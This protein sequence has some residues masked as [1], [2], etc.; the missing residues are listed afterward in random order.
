MNAKKRLMVL[1]LGLGLAAGSQAQTFTLPVVADTFLREG[2]ANQ[3]GGG[4]AVLQLSGNQRVLLRVDQAAVISAAGSGRLVS[5]S[6]E[7]Y[8]RSAS[9]WGSG[10]Q[11]VEAHRLTADW[12]EAGATWSCGIDTQPTNGRPDCAAQWAG[13]TFEED[14]SDTVLHTNDTHGWVR[15]DVTA[16][17]AAFLAGASNRGWLLKR[18]DESGGGRADYASREGAAAERPRLVLLVETS[19]NDQVPPSLAITAPVRSILVNEPSPTV[20]LEY[21]DGG[22]GVDTATLQLLLDGQDATASCTSGPQSA[23]CHP[24]ALTAGNHTL[25]ARLRDRSGNQAQASFSFQ[26]LLGTG[27]HLVA[28]QAVADTYV[29]KGGANQNQGTEPVV[30]VQQGGND[31]VLVQFDP[32]SLSATLAG[33][34]LVSAALELHV[35][36]NGRNWGPQGRTVD[37]HRVTSAWT[38][39]G[40]SWN[41]P[42]DSNP[43]NSQPDCASQWN[44]G[45]FAAAP[46]A[47]VLHTRDLAGWVSFNVTADVAAFVSGT[48]NRGWLIKKTDEK[49]SGRMDYD[50]RQGTAREGPRLVVVFEAA[51]GGDTEAPV[52]AVTSPAAGSFVASATPTITATYSDGGSGVD[53]ASVRLLLD[54]V[55]RTAAA[56]V[57]A[58]GLTFTPASSLAEGEHLVE[59]T[60][61]DSA[62]NE[63]AASAGFTTDTG[64]PLLTIT[65]PPSTGP[66]DPTPEIAVAYSDSTSGLDLAALRI[67]LDGADLLARCVVSPSSSTCEPQSLA[68]GVHEVAASIRDRAGNVATATRTFELLSDDVPPSITLTSPAE[69]AFFK[70]PTILVSGH[71]TDNQGL[72]SVELNGTPVAVLAG[73]AFQAPLALAEGPNSL[74]VTAEDTAGNE[75]SATR[76]VVLD[77]KPPRLVLESPSDGQ[78]T[79][80]GAVRVAGEVT[81]DQSLAELVIQGQ[82]VPVAGGRFEAS[83]PLASGPNSILVRAVDRAGNETAATVEV[84][85]FTL[86]N[87]TITSP[88]DL[89]FLAATTVDVEGTVSDAQSSVAVNGVA[90]EISGTSYRAREVPLIEGGNILTATA[91]DAN[92]H[93]GSATINVVRDLTA[94]R[95]AITYPPSE[96]V[97]TQPTVAVSGMVNDIVAGT[98]NAA[99]ATV[100]VNGLPASVSNRSF[101]VRDVPLTEGENV[102]SVVATDVSGNVGEAS[103]T[104]FF[105]APS[106]ARISVVSGDLQEGVIGTALPAPLVVALADA[107]G[108][109]VAGRPVLFKVREGSGTLDGG[110]RLIAVTTDASGRATAHFTLGTRSGGASDVV[111]A[112]A[113]GYRG[114]AVFTAS[115]RSGDPAHLVVDS[116]D[117]Q[118]GTAGQ[119]LPRP[120]V[121]VVTDAGFNRLEGFPIKFTIKKGQGHFANGLQE[122]LISSDS[123]GRAIAYLVLDTEEGVANNVVEAR[124]EGLDPSPVVG[125]VA[126]GWI[127]GDPAMTSVSGVVLDNSNVPVAGATLR[128]L[129]TDL[130]AQ[131][132]EQGKFLIGGAPV[133]TVKLIVDGST[134]TRPGSW[135]DL[136]FVLTTIAGRENTI[137]MPIYLLPLD[138]QNGAVIDEVR[139][140]VITLPEIPGFAL[141]IAPGSVIFPGG[142]RSG[143]VS[144]TAVHN[145][146]VPMVPNFGQQPRFIVTIQPA[147]ARFDPPARLILPNVEGLAPGAV[148]EMY[149]FDHDLGH[150][151]SIGP[152]TVSEDGSV[153]RSNPGV[154]ILKAGWHCGGN[155]ATAGTPHDCPG[156]T[157]CVDNQCVPGC[158]LPASFQVSTALP[159]AAG[160][161]TPTDPCEVPPGNCLPGGGCQGVPVNVTGLNGPCIVEQGTLASFSASSNEDSK[162][163]WTASGGMPTTGQGPSFDVQFANP[164]KYTVTAYCK[165]SNDKQIDV[166]VSC[167]ATYM[168]DVFDATP[169]QQSAFGWTGYTGARPDLKACAR[170]TQACVGL[171]AYH[172]GEKSEVPTSIS[173]KTDLT[174]VNAAVSNNVINASNCQRVIDDFTPFDPCQGPHRTQFWNSVITAKHEKV[175]YDQIRTDVI[176]KTA[177]EFDNYLKSAC[178]QCLTQ[179]PVPAQFFQEL[180]K[181]FQ[182][183]RLVYEAQKECKAHGDSNPDYVI[184]VDTLR[185]I[186]QTKGWQC[187]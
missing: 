164:G 85:R 23:S 133:G 60:V 40:A 78:S 31:R 97:L 168:L 124:V 185:Q 43:A 90:A 121:A 123:D 28:F 107:A 177:R 137:R 61:R 120:L 146:K 51:G 154:G 49:K 16:D 105:Q 95:L 84:S 115:A 52:V 82:T 106:G 79:N 136:E 25:Q 53:T 182:A 70:T 18:E 64:A 44:G 134:V 75:S 127:A 178:V 167:P 181:I 89:S 13:G 46:T 12:T 151:V 108:Q 62:G 131:T 42:V 161:C 41:C 55:N 2:G 172:Q 179:L 4:D 129:D 138:L 54:R 165:N 80:Q 68:P 155:P 5:A 173:G 166:A 6:L 110:K 94:P 45:S 69:G 34:T 37:A 142:S 112:V 47:S 63:A 174:D 152:A 186:A 17:V 81:D 118:V 39:L 184:F 114:P 71:A 122:I 10:G 22:S 169:T 149:S 180:D 109:P 143:L 171:S 128:I 119:L 156:C 117:Q 26:L 147:G 24:S 32:Q 88:A 91:T 135:P 96:A 141:E 100:V 72:A 92:G 125:F 33:A 116:G 77:F 158:R 103:I 15:F 30:R 104:V 111:E 159:K 11:S 76:S 126:S 66:A 8:A 74:L 21:A 162:I 48:P 150:F 59:I 7:L 67:T 38:E 3:N 14:S 113:A 175:H 93:I 57:T 87:V 29:R 183:N 65:S 73:G 160:C 19:A 99:Q 58:S 163:K 176:E 36:E 187:H 98:V 132:D 20:T 145:D 102:L 153:I 157:I 144:V 140:G 170:G 86:P 50:S 35:E 9:G 148:T 56:Q 139:G 101:L 130:S 1:V 83:V 27:P